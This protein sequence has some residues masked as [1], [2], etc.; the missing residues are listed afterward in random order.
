MKE[1]VL[2]HITKSLKAL[3]LGAFFLSTLQLNAQDS[4]IGMFNNNLAKADDYYVNGNYLE[5]IRI[6]KD[7]AQSKEAPS[8]I[9]LRLARSYYF[10]HNYANA[11][12]KYEKFSEENRLSEID[13]FYYAESLTSIGDYQKALEIYQQAYSKDQQNEM[14]AARIWRLNNI[15]YLLED[16]LENAVKYISINT[17][18]SE[19]KAS[20][21]DDGVVFTSNKP[22]VS[23]IKKLDTKAGTSFYHFYR[24]D[25][26]PDPFDINALVYEDS[27]PFAQSLGANY[28]V[29]SFSFFNDYNE[30]VLSM[31]AAKPNAKGV[32]PL[33]IFFAR[34]KG[35][36]WSIVAEFP[37]NNIA[38]SL[39][40]PWMNEGGTEIYFS[41]EIPGGYGG[42]DIYK[43]VLTDSS[44]SKP[45]NV[46][47]VINTAGDEI[48]PFM[49]Q[50]GIFYFASNGHPGLGGFDLFKVKKIGERYGELENLGYPINSGFDDFALSID[51]LNR[52]GFLTSNRKRGGLDDDIY[53]FDMGLQSYPLEVSGKVKFI[54]HN[55]MDSTELELL[56]N[57]RMV[58]IDNKNQQKV[59]ETNSDK[60]GNFS[61]TVPYYSQYKIRIVSDELDG[62]VS[63]EVP[64][65]SKA[66]DSYEIVVVND[67]F[68]KPK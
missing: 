6:Y 16:S 53:E 37:H 28:H 2:H 39:Y 62:I 1:K 4:V 5:A 54:E 60:E 30:M 34:K 12:L 66:N 61:F 55:W 36:K 24:T 42:K 11:K 19:L 14:L 41:A 23:L 40:E 51:S 65:Y 52:H 20:L 13:K 68:K 15:N 50:D 63:F 47:E 32:Y 10:T 35:K 43:S 8:T 64:K 44:W 67:D 45:G 29:A 59:L 57:V 9:N 22:A 27:E 25:T 21:Y 7:L 33:Q 31:S 18:Y 48:H 3:F 38:Y 17:E 58:L 49:G 46:G 26:R 56:P